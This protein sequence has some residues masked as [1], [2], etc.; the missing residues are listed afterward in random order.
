MGRLGTAW[1][2]PFRWWIWRD[3]RPNKR[4]RVAL[5]VLLIPVAIGGVLALIDRPAG[6]TLAVERPTPAKQLTVAANRGG[7]SGWLKAQSSVVV[8]NEFSAGG[9][10]IPG[11]QPRQLELALP[12][13][14]TACLQLRSEIGGMCDEVGE[15]PTLAAGPLVVEWPSTGDVAVEMHGS[16]RLQLRPTQVSG[17]AAPYRALNLRVDAPATEV[18]F[19]CTERAGFRLVFGGRV[20]PLRCQYGP[21]KYRV[22]FTYDHPSAPRLFLSG[23]GPWRFKG[24]GTEAKAWV[25]RGLLSIG[26]RER[27]L[28]AANTKV[29]VDA[30]RPQGVS[31]VVGNLD[32]GDQ[33]DFTVQTQSA[34]SVEVSD[35]QVLPSHLSKYETYWLLIIGIAGGVLLTIYLERVPGRD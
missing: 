6:A 4:E 21:A 35:E 2:N 27:T 26:D 7:G 15:R 29:V 16:K 22:G 17:A 33:V 28:G 11:S 30:A 24:L 12:V 19:E 10:Q 1:V 23:L 32:S 25:D 18:R 13:S 31:A 3:L 20:I 5:T 8:L 9:S 14:R 34:D